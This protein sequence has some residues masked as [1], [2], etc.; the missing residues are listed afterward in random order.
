MSI[1]AGGRKYFPSDNIAQYIAFCITGFDKISKKG[2]CLL[3][4]RLGSDRLES[5]K[6]LN[7]I[8]VNVISRLLQAETKDPFMK[9]YEKPLYVTLLS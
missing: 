8:T 1:K 3:N 9:I 6:L 2:S 7:V 5:V 4:M